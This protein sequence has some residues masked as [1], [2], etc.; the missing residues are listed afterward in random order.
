MSACQTRSK[1]VR[2]P[3]A[4]ALG[5]SSAI[6]LIGGACFSDDPADPMSPLPDECRELAVAA[7]VNPDA[8]GVTVVGIKDFAFVPSTVSVEP[9][10]E[11]VWV[12]CEPAGTPGGDHTSTSEDDLWDSTLL[13]RGEIYRR[14]FDDV[15]S[16]D[17]YCIPHRFFMEGSVTVAE[18]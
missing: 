13:S 10:T 6:V 17:Y 5:L 3:F 4:A 7:G 9:G 16:F 1:T 2:R 8:S 14:F 18:P 12:N 11:V 15:G